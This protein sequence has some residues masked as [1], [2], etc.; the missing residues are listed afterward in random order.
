LGRFHCLT[1]DDLAAV[2]FHHIEVAV[3]IGGLGVGVTHEVP[4]REVAA[5]SLVQD[6]RLVVVR[7]AGEFEL[8]DLIFSGGLFG[9][10]VTLAGF[11]VEVGLFVIPPFVFLSGIKS[12]EVVFALGH[13]NRGRI[14]GD[15][16]GDEVVAAIA[17]SLVAL[18]FEGVGLGFLCLGLY[19][20]VEE[21]V[22]G[23]AIKIACGIS[24]ELLVTVIVSE[25]YTSTIVICI[26]NRETVVS[27][28]QGCS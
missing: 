28:H 25:S 21:E 5:F 22:V 3:D 12:V 9:I 16:R 8:E 20:E 14:H 11:E 7:R 17:A 2:L 24:T 23:V 4:A 1:R 15:G 26:G 10:E 27:L 19:E 13:T 18:D 6:D